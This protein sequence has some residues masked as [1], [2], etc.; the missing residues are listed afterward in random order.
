MA[1]AR[2]LSEAGFQA[3]FVGGAV[4]D[5]LLGI[6]ETVE[7]EFDIA[8]SAS[9]QEVQAI[10]PQTVAVGASF[11]VVKVI[12]PEGTYDVATFRSD[13][14]V[15]DGRHPASVK[16]A[17]LE[18]DV[19][20]RDFTIN[21]LVEDPVSGKVLDLVDGKK[22]L[23]ARV[24]RTIGD[25]SL[26]FQEDGLRLLRAIRFAARFDFS[27]EEKTAQAIRSEASRLDLVSAERICD[28]MRRMLMDSSRCSAIELLDGHGLLDRVLPEVVAMKG[29]EQPPEFHPEGDVWVHTLLA[30]EK[31]PRSSTFELALATLLHD[32]GKPP[33][34]VRAEDRI[35]FHGHVELGAT[36]SEAICRRLRMA[37]KATDRV[38]ALVRDHLLFKDVPA[39]RPGRLRR[40]LASSHYEELELLYIADCEASHGVMSALPRIREIQE[41]VAKEDLIPEPL[42]TGKDLLKSGVA[43]GPEIGDILREVLDLQM[44]GTLKN[45]E[46]ALAWLKNRLSGG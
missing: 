5:G 11:G 3:V 20:R 7:T 15:G 4:R 31:L 27:I 13:V 45:R 6:P 40:M 46:E 2:G 1:V 17:T 34:F 10:F 44:E 38:V 36:M 9:P 22:D 37:K 28:E 16:P 35:R 18:E 39:M 23:E 26:R 12:Q 24:I 25:P 29:V 30:L 42:L 32:V 8:T 19:Q 33:T 41:Q 43:P 14:G 21:G